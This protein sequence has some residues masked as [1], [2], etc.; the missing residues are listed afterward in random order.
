[1]LRSGAARAGTWIRGAAYLPKWVVLG[2]GIG[3]IAGLGAVA[4]YRTLRF[5]TWLFMHVIADYRPPFP[6]GEGGGSGTGHFPHGW[7]IPIIVCLGGLVTGLVVQRLAPEAE[8][9]GTDAAIDAV[10][11]NPRMVRTRAVI[12][13]LI[14]SALMIGSGGSGGREGPTAQIS[15]GFGSLL[16]RTLDLSPE[17]G[18]TA[19]SVGIGAG[20][21]SIFSAPLGGAVLAADIIYMDDFEVEAL[22]PGLIASIVGYTVFGLIDGF[23]PMFGYVAP[24]YEFHEPLQL[25]WFALIGACAGFVGLAYSR[26]FHGTVRLF[27]RMRL[28]GFLKPAIGGLATG[29]LALALPEVLGTGY[30]WVQ[31]SLGR[32]ELMAIPLWVVLLLPFAKIAATAFSI[33]SGGSGGIF[34]P[35]IVIGAFTGA[36]IWRLLAPIAPGVPHSPAPFVIVGMMA[37]FG[38]IARAP[39]AVMLMVAEMTGSL[40]ILAP[41]MV[42]VG[43]A[44]LIVRGSGETIYR[45]QL[46]SRDDA[47]AARLR[48]GMPLLA[49]VSVVQAMVPPRLVITDTKTASEA[50]DALRAAG[51]PGAPVIDEERHFLGDISIAALDAAPEE[52]HDQ[53]VARRVDAAAPSLAEDANLDQALQALV[54]GHPWLTVLGPQR[55]VR[56][57]LAISDLVRA[58]RKQVR[59]DAH[60]ISRASANAVLVEEPVGEHSPLI[61]HP[62]NQAVLPEATVVL[63]VQRGDTVSLGL[64]TSP[65]AAGDIVTALARPD[66]VDDIRALLGLSEPGSGRATAATPV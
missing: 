1:R 27:R 61:G 24:G 26:G 55:E 36:A 49:R 37:C 41:A 60:R 28:P 29:L 5:A 56:G 39:L 31:A 25:V 19:V 62:L 6:A 40:T 45:S 32:P 43:I 8:G 63:S 51:V 2:T 14:A 65:V 11:T 7:L 17:D 23:N 16:A 54:P 48:T 66:H 52:A 3:L 34:G 9:H 33:G 57:T 47:R 20:I 22:I 50:R 46:R 12:V 58:Y 64:A 44:Y 42:A 30:G 35:G 13:K 15:A 53:P 21:G 18:R 38:A 10:H 4:F 59:T